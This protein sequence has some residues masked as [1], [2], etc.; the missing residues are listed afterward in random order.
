[1][2]ENAMSLSTLLLSAVA[3]A[4]ISGS[5]SAHTKAEPVRNFVL[6]HG[7]FADGSG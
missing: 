6:V 7:A 1:M 3:V 2:L 4:A 5:A